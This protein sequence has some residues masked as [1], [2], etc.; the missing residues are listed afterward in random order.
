M[1]LAVILILA[2]VSCAPGSLAPADPVA[3]NLSLTSVHGPLP[4]AA[5]KARLSLAYEEPGQMLPGQRRTIHLLVRNASQLIWP[6]SAEFDGRYQ[7]KAGNRWL[8]QD[9]NSKED[10]R[11]ALPYDLTP[12]A[13]AEVLL[14]ITAPATS[15]NYILE[16][17]MVQEQVAW[18]S[19]KGSEKLR[20]SLLVE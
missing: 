10:G 4:G 17:D 2:Q 3:D 9:G 16:F 15:G 8:G 20:M 11:G 7:I 5:Y 13:S 12:G 18:F 19:E 1:L 6:Y 14:V